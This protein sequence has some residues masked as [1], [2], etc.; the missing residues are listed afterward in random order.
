MKNLF[1][2]IT[3]SIGTLL[4]FLPATAIAKGNS[5]EGILSIEVEDYEDH[6]QLKYWLK[7]KQGKRTE[8]LLE[9]KPNWLKTGQKLRIHG[10]PQGNK[11]A[12]EEE[13][14]SLLLSNETTTTSTTTTSTSSLTN[15]VSGNRTILV[16]EVNFAINPMVRFTS[17]EIYDLVFNQSSQFFQENSYGAVSFSGDALEPITIDIDTSTCN[18]NLLADEADKIFRQRGY[19]PNGY[20]HVMYLIPTHKSCTWGGQANV[21]GPRSWISIVDLATINHEL[22]HNFGLKHAHKKDCGTVTTDGASCTVYTYGDKLSGMSNTSTAKHFNGFHKEQLGWLPGRTATLTSSGV[23]AL[24]ALEVED[25]FAP[26][27]LKIHK[28]VDTNGN[29]IWYYIEYRQ[30]QGFNSSLET[31]D[32]VYLTGV[33]LREGIDNQHDSSNLLD[34][35][36][37]S[38]SSSNDDWDDITIAPGQ[39]YQD[40]INNLAIS[41]ISSDSSQVLVDVHYGISSSQCSKQAASFELLSNSSVSAEPSDDVN[42]SYRIVNND[43]QDCTATSFDLTNNFSSGL[44]GNFDLSQLNLS[45]GQSQTVNLSVTVSSTAQD[46]NYSVHSSVS[47]LD[48]NQSQSLSSTI[49]VSSATGSNS[50]PVA[51]NDDIIIESKS[52]VIIAVLNNDYDPD[53]DDLTISATGQGAKGRVTLNTNNTLTYTPAKSFKSTDSFSYSI[54]DGVLTTSAT[55]YLSLQSSG[56]GGNGGG[57]GKNNK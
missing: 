43:S 7:D 4:A 16:A 13:S 5:L 14:I 3:M 6:A 9:K 54:S 49:S 56:G 21:N 22:G 53:S 38:A 50:A 1:L 45:P 30:A 8:I 34:P 44:N 2:G 46:G 57:K 36:P 55:V 48:N 31:W 23:V 10:N 12:V 11:F 47:R 26:K 20:D 40:S 37:N 25:T 27:V 51:V 33:R 18:T 17:S 52:S 39:T 41:V 24:S 19:E 15:A 32:P 42:F 35:T 28:G 29:N